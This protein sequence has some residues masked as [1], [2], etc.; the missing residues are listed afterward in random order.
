MKEKD[1]VKPQ[2]TPDERKLAKIAT[3]GGMYIWLQT[4][5]MSR[6]CHQCVWD[7]CGIVVT[8]FNAVA[9]QQKSMKS[10]EDEEKSKKKKGLL[11]S[12]TSAPAAAAAIST[13]STAAPAGIFIFHMLLD[14]SA[15]MNGMLTGT[16]YV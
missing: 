16:M 1:H 15:C 3:R 14:L 9:K 5:C 6:E 12:T 13:P 8:L 11:S 4:M 2:F 10:V 7:L